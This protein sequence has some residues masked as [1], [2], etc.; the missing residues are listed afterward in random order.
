MV[1]ADVWHFD[2]SSVYE[3][4]GVMDGY[5]LVQTI[6]QVLLAQSTRNLTPIVADP[7]DL[8]KSLP[9]L[10]VVPDGCEDTEDGAHSGVVW[11][12]KIEA[13]WDTNLVQ[14]REAWLHADANLKGSLHWVIK[15]LDEF[16]D[17]S[18]GVVPERD[19]DFQ[20][21]TAQFGKSQRLMWHFERHVSIEIPGEV[22]EQTQV[23]VL[24]NPAFP[25]SLGENMDDVWGIAADNEND[26]LFLTQG[27]ASTL[28][29]ARIHRINLK[30]NE[31]MAD[32]AAGAAAGAYRRGLD[33]ADGFLFLVDD[34]TT[35]GTW[36]LVKIEVATDTVVATAG[37]GGGEF[38]G[39]SVYGDNG[40]YVTVAEISGAGTY[41]RVYS[42]A[43]LSRVPS[44]EDADVTAGYA[45]GVVDIG[46]YYYDVIG[47]T[48]VGYDSTGRRQN[49]DLVLPGARRQWRGAT[50]RDTHLWVAGVSFAQ[51]AP[52]GVIGA[53][54]LPREVTAGLS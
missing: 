52:A 29:E 30:T 44:E 54:R 36:T 23:A 21:M 49:L 41:W 39:L 13:G 6:T 26:V 10:R 22:T 8:P 31:A 24:N 51:A 19:W 28:A 53:L 43:D 37:L 18:I 33:Y 40:E 32:L 12:F 27:H 46:S 34:Q 9:Y 42:T 1:G 17:D 14:R 2:A 45:A 47:Q 50:R 16:T 15:R 3:G 38:T 11:R 35:R 4:D 5:G 25:P 20:L 7:A 48:A